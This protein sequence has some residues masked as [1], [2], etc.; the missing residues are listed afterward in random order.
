VGLMV[1]YIMDLIKVRRPTATQ[2]PI[3]LTIE[4]IE[5]SNK[6]RQFFQE[7]KLYFEFLSEFNEQNSAPGPHYHSLEGQRFYYVDWKR[8]Y[9]TVP[10]YC[11]ECKY[12]SDEQ[13]DCH[14]VHD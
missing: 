5:A 2:A 3:P 4:S 1:D 6:Y 10:L 8:A 14:L 12:N 9:P 11:F 13:V 7:G